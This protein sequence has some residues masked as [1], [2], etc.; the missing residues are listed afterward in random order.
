[1]TKTNITLVP[2][3]YTD[4][5]ALVTSIGDV[6]FTPTPATYK[7]LH[8]RADWTV[9]KQFLEEKD[10]SELKRL[11]SPPDMVQ[12]LT[13]C[14]LDAAEKAISRKSSQPPL[15]SYFRKPKIWW[16]GT[17]KVTVKKNN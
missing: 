14:V 1:M 5:C 17:T 16:K 8:C 9:F 12:S 7:F 10:Y 2:E 11:A 13:Y 4:Q 3:L 15:R 6:S